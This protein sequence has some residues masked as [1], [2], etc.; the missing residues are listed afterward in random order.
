MILYHTSQAEEYDQ[1]LIGRDPAPIETKYF[2]KTAGTRKRDEQQAW[3]VDAMKSRTHGSV[4]SST[5][6]TMQA[7]CA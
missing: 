1:Q 3:K 2:M 4:H 7:A 5:N 6:S